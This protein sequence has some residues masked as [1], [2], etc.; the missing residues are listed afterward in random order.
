MTA[1]PLPPGSF[2]E[3]LAGTSEHAQALYRAVLPPFAATGAPPSLPAAAEHAG[4]STEQAAAAL[5]ELAEADVVALDDDGDLVG[6]FPLSATPTRHRVQVGDR[7]VLHAMCAIDA[8]G[9]P[10]MLGEPGVISSVDPADDSPVTVTV[11]VDGT[12]AADPP[13]AVV[14]LGASGDGGLASSAC[15]VIDFYA[16]AEN[17]HQALSRP[18]LS[19]DVLT[20]ADAHALG[21]ALFADLPATPRSSA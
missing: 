3:R 19:G 7:P 17:A 21:V 14:L 1:G 6:A 5:R 12:L 18:G 11:G 9:V 16:S 13:A 4:L 8:L 15:P 2:A 20:V 10:A